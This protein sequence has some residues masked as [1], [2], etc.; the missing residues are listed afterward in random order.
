MHIIKRNVNWII[1]SK[2]YV[3]ETYLHKIAEVDA[4]ILV[5]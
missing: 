1:A 4:T 3:A 5:R 2:N